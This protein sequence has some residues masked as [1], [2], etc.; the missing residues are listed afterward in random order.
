MKYAFVMNSGTLNPE[1][2]STVY[3]ENGSRYFFSAV[4]GMKM[5]RE[6][7]K[8][9]ADEGYELLDLCGDYTEEKA[10][11]TRNS[12]GGRLKVNFAKYSEEDLKRF[13][14]LESA[15]KY[16]IIV[17][18]FHPGEDLVKLEL[19]SEEFNTYIAI[20]GTEKIAAQAAKDMV[21]EGIHFIELCGYF[22]AEK[23]EVVA[24]SIGY[25]VPLGYCG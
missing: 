21:E 2:Y 25:A 1:I 17:L 8:R 13:D 15:N 9:L 4:H 16:G 24:K 7:A 19:T 20:A 18:A 3:E 12:S 11:E 5:T 14:A 23:A 6:L 22:D 10:E